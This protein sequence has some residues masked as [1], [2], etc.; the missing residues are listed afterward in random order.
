MLK[1]KKGVSP[2]AVDKQRAKKIAATTAVHSGRTVGSII[3][4][5]FKIIGTVLLVG[6]TTGA[7]F[8]MIFALYIRTTLE[9]QIDITLEEFTLNLTST[10]F[11]FDHETG[12]YVEAV[13]VESGEVRHWVPYEEINRY[14][15][16]AAVAF[17]D[18]RFYDHR[19]VDWW[20]TVGAFYEM[21][22]GEGQIYGASTITQQLIKNLTHQDEVT[23]RRKLLEIFR[24]M[25]LERL[26]TK[27]E[28][29]EWY[30]NV[31]ALGGRINGVGAA[32][33]F[34]YGVDQSELTLA[35][36]A[37]IVGITQRPTF[38]NP[39]LNLE[40][41]LR[42]RNEVLA[43]MYAQGYIT[44]AQYTEAVNERIVL[45]Q[46]DGTT[47]DAPIYSFFEETIINDLV[48]QFVDEM[49]LSVEAARNR[50]F[51]GGLQIYSAMD[52]RIQ[53]V[54]DEAFSD[55]ANLPILRSPAQ[56]AMI[57][58]DQRTGHIVGM[59]GGIGE[60]TQNMV[61]NRATDALRPPGSAIKPI[62]VYGPAMELGVLR[63]T[64]SIV[65][66]PVML[67]GRP[68]PRNVDGVWTH[69]GQ[70]LVRALSRSTNTVAVHALDR[71][72]VAQSYEFMTERLHINLDPADAARA[73]LA[74]GQLTHGLTIREI[75]AAYA[76]FANDGIFTHPVTYSLVLDANGDVIFDNT[77]GRQEVAFRVE[78]AGQM[79]AMLLDAVVNG[80]GRS[81]M[82]S[83]MDVAGKT[84]STEFN[85][86]RWFAGYT[87]H[88]TASVW[89]GFDLMHS[90]S[91][92]GNN[93][94]VAIFQRIM[95]DA[96]IAAELPPARFQGLPS[97]R[98]TTQ[99]V[100]RIQ[101]CSVSRDLATSACI[102]YHTGSLAIPW[103]GDEDSAPT[104]HCSVHA[105]V[106]VCSETHLRANS[107]CP[108]ISV[109]FAIGGGPAG[110][111]DIQHA[112]S[113]NDGGDDGN[114]GGDD[115]NG[116]GD[117]GNGGGD[118]GNG[119]GDD[120]NGG[121]DDGNG[122]DPG[123][124]GVEQQEVPPT[125][126][127]V[128][129]QGITLEPRALPPAPP[130]LPEPLDDGDGSNPYDVVPASA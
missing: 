68:W 58:M 112:G 2:L 29:L 43:A 31:F 30:L 103:T 96:H 88:L 62:S 106:S 18:R 16:Y 118:D 93:P 4:L 11:E 44:H 117:D 100:E 28:I 129:P 12:R 71:L 7:V 81:A 84:G 57:I 26:Y 15:I 52:P 113:G 17:E 66:A 127:E 76:A 46:V 64:D 42:K 108:T 128:A 101:I 36:S 13:P 10:I 53:G 73:P 86:D 55:W 50:V 1:K 87:P 47:F 121:G 22:L 41:N 60:K 125:P 97:L 3:G 80:T 116:G 79:T 89:T 45:A 82:I 98:G 75:T 56:S 78:I 91:L 85:R 115:G 14:L 35:Q 48:R 51:F 38:Y 70:N 37:S 9:P 102:N 54:L 105:L 34:Y 63:P 92:P 65:D 20:R 74:L 67:N 19:G 119:G 114:G 130:R 120:G 126:Q 6:L 110:T 83:G 39:Y 122:A 123:S 49:D 21:F 107:T 104:A 32:A 99:A 8:S 27:E 109:G 61:F 23:V 25:E 24:A 94:A 72:G 95:R 40:N 69:A 77:V 33:M 111:C 59:A 124:Q 90:G 5:V